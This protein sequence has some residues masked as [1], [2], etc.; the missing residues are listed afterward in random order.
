[1]LK[2]SHPSQEGVLNVSKWLKTQ[3]L[4]SDAE[5]RSLLDHLNPFSFYNVSEVVTEE[6]I[7]QELFLNAYTRY[8][9]TL[10]SGKVLEDKELRRFFSAALSVTS[11]AL[12][13]ME[14]KPGQFLIKAIKPILQMQ[15]H[16]FLPSKL[17]G[18]FHPMVLSQD[19]VS[20][21]LQFSYPQ[22]CQNPRTNLFA[23][24]VKSEEFPNTELFDKLMKWLRNFS[25][26][27][28][29]V[30]E[31]KKTSVPMRLGKECFSWIEAHPELK[32]KGIQVYV[33][34]N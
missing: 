32:E 9:Q 30:W 16:Q 31:G 33:Y 14:V 28:T 26:P 24:V 23:K 21:G 22:I 1:M 10:K 8:A 11:E 27:T 34:S 4:L 5:M 25:V 19:S 6:V 7:P 12:Y 15:L 2:L 29:F 13:K 18:K 17:D 20:W 3:V